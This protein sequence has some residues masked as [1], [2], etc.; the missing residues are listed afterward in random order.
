MLSP[1]ERVTLFKNCRF[2]AAAPPAVLQQLAANAVGEAV[3]AGTAVVT[4]GESGHT[5]YIIAAG[6]VR[7]HDGEVTLAELGRGELFGE[8]TVLDE[9]VRSATVTALEDCRL[10][11]IERGMLFEALHEHPEGFEREWLDGPVAL[12]VSNVIPFASVAA[13]YRSSIR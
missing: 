9:Q 3:P 5:M 11:T 6:R 10:L 4:A 12:L 1:D 13:L 7:V 2:L 8:M